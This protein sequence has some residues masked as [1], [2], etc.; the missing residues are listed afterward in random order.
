LAEARRAG[1]SALKIITIEEAK[2]ARE[3]A[4]AGTTGAST[5]T[6]K[7]D[8]ELQKSV[9]AVISKLS[10]ATIAADTK[11]SETTSS[12][13]DDVET[14]QDIDFAKLYGDG[15]D[16]QAA[17]AAADA[18][19]RQQVFAGMVVLLAREVPQDTTEF[20]LLN[21][22]ATVIRASA[23]TEEQTHNHTITHH[24]VDRPLSTGHRRILT[25][26]YVQPQWIFDSF[27]MRALL[28]T[29]P[30][31]PGVSPPPH[32]SPFVDDV[33]VGY[34]PKQREVLEK[35]KNAALG[36]TEAA[37]LTTDGSTV[38]DGVTLHRPDDEAKHADALEAQYARDL[39]KEA[40]G[41]SFSQNKPT[42]T[43][44]NDNDDSDSKEA[45][46]NDNDDSDDDNDDNDNDDE[47]EEVNTINSNVIVHSNDTS[48]W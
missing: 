47:E 43:T 1:L 31:A 46:D 44:D 24:I 23:L 25:R 28:P 42:T 22:G 16:T 3:A 11:S 19:S 14:K 36:I 27:N 32:L 5:A 33:A 21:G 45:K 12:S 2:A 38:P 35:W 7:A 34:I 8:K 9:A 29:E 30:Y 48:N 6:T 18:S 4:A 26:V 15:S 41:T 13:A 37:S 39:A 10:P 17:A 20:V 40:A